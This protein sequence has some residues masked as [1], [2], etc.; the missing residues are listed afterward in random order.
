MPEIEHSQGFCDRLRQATEGMNYRQVGDVVRFSCETVRRYM[1]G[2]ALP[3]VD[4]IAAVCER[5]NV[6]AD[7]LVMGV[8]PMR[9]EDRHREA[10]RD[11][12]AADIFARVA[13][14]VEMKSEI[15][16]R[17]PHPVERRR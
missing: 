7:W 12:S 11:A 10:L 2:S 4:F 5:L 8:G 1:I 15:N 16:G 14:L 13:E 17:S 9:P 6:S 3:R